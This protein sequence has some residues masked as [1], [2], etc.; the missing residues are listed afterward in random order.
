MAIPINTLAGPDNPSPAIHHMTQLHDWDIG[1]G[2][3]RFAMDF[4]G[5]NFHGD[6]H[7]H[8]DALCHVAYADR[9]YGGRPECPGW[10]PVKPSPGRS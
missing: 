9:L 2:S 1:S 10:S 6:C 3:L 8:I 7:T 4:L 5:M